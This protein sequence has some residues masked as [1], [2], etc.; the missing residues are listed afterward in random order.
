[1]SDETEEI[2]RARVRKRR[3][4]VFLLPT[5]RANGVVGDCR[6]KPTVEQDKFRSVAAQAVEDG[7]V[8]IQEWIKRF[9]ETHG[10]T[11]TRNTVSTWFKDQD[12]TI[13]FMDI[14]P[15][16]MSPVERDISTAIAERALASRAEAGEPNAVTALIKL[17]GNTGGGH[18]AAARKRRDLVAA[19]VRGTTGK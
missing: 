6:Y 13:W 5:A 17:R 8:E 11:V 18:D 19:A 14:M 15:S 7:K 9:A 12:F 4:N 10:L 2:E 16:A 1:M 3:P